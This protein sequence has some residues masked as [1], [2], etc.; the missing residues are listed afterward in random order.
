MSPCQCSSCASLFV[1]ACQVVTQA[2]AC[3]SCA[4]MYV[5]ALVHYIVHYTPEANRVVK[6]CAMAIVLKL[7]C[8]GWC[9]VGPYHICGHV[10]HQQRSK[11]GHELLLLL[12]LEL[13]LAYQG[14]AGQQRRVAPILS[15]LG[16]FSFRAKNNSIPRMPFHRS[17]R[18]R[19]RILLHLQYIVADQL[20]TL[21]VF[22]VK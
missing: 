1:F 22:A 9:R 20:C 10:C 21:T 6:A 18:L 2:L 11:P 4:N 19:V 3:L 5:T 16:M 15:T 12:R 13:S 17:C 7:C 14:K 8:A